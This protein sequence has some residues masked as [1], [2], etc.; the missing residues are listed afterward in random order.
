MNDCDFAKIHIKI[1]RRSDRELITVLSGMPTK[2][3]FRTILKKIKT[4][5]C[6][7]GILENEI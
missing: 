6:C 4:K 5:F 2:F 1:R 7:G 3:D